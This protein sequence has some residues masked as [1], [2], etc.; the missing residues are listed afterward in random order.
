VFTYT[1]R[2]CYVSVSTTRRRRPSIKNPKSLCPLCIVH[3]HARTHG[4]STHR[5]RVET[6]YGPRTCARTGFSISDSIRSAAAVMH[7]ARVDCTRSRF[8]I[9]YDAVPDESKD[10]N[11]VHVSFLSYR[12]KCTVRIRIEAEYVHISAFVSGD[13]TYSVL[14]VQTVI[15]Y[16]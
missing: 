3:T 5:I 7:L 9:F 16:R 2:T 8:I 15:G 6:V 10:L 11:I 4:K 13:G 1:P 12:R 14:P